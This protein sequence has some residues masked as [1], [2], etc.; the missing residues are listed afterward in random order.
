MTVNSDNRLILF[1]NLAG[2]IVTYGLLGLSPEFAGAHGAADGV[3]G[4]CW[5]AVCSS[6]FVFSDVFL[7]DLL[8]A[9]FLKPLDPILGPALVEAVLDEVH[10]RERQ[11]QDPDPPIALRRQ[12]HRREPER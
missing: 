11:Q 2:V 5:S 7:E 8:V 3:D 4:P 9:R 10:Q 6:R 1:L 12:I